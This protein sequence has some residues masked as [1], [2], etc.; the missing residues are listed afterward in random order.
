M[1]FP[2]SFRGPVPVFSSS[3]NAL[4]RIFPGGLFY[5]NEKKTTHLFKAPNLGFFQQSFTQFFP[6]VIQTTHADVEKTQAK[7]LEAKVG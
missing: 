1:S 7:D 6:Q 4:L 3:Q 2:F 5:P